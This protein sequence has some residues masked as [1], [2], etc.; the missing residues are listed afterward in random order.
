MLTFRSLAFQALRTAE[1]APVAALEQQTS[2]SSLARLEP[3]AR[4]AEAVL[5][6][7]QLIV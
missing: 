6:N 5:E 3:L 2:T 4:E 1:L 7:E